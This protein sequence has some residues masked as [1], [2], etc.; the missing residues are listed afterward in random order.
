MHLKFYLP[1][2]LIGGGELIT[3]ALLKSIAEG[4]RG[5]TQSLFCQ[6]SNQIT[7]LTPTILNELN[8]KNKISLFKKLILSFLSDWAKHHDTKH[9]AILSGMIIYTGWINLFFWQK[10]ICI[11]HSNLGQFYFKEGSYHKRIMRIFLYN[12]ALLRAEKL[13]FVSTEA[14]RDSI[15]KLWSINRKKATVVRNPIFDIGEKLTLSDR[16]TGSIDSFLIVGRF[17]P[18]KRIGEALQFLMSNQ[19][20]QR[21]IIVSNIDPETIKKYKSLPNFNFYSDYSQVPTLSIGNTVLLNF[22]LVESFSLV[23]GEWLKAKGRVFSTHGSSCN[24]IWA[25]SLGFYEFHENIDFNSQ[26]IEMESASLKDNRISFCGYDIVD[27]RDE[28][29]KVIGI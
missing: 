1:Q 14:M 24:S 20:N 8:Y 9:I 25:D 18:E 15:I 28:F 29:L 23:I 7:T 10:L 26:I 3:I 4:N 5:I 16:D 19:L 12:V 21:I 11:E 17:S 2:Y 6:G 27:Y 13:I 22:G